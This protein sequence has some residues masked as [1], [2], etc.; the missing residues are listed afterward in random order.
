MLQSYVPKFSYII[1]FRFRS[2]RI[3]PLKRVIEW[4]SGFQGVE[5]I[6]VE[7][8]THSKIDYMNLK[9]NHVF[10]PSSAPF[11]KSWAFNVGLRRAISPVI[12]F[13]DADFI[14]HPMELIECLK[15]LDGYDCVIPT[16]KV[17][18]LTQQQSAMDTASLLQQNQFMM[19]KNIL[20]GI[21]IFKRD[22]LNKIAGW[23]EDLIGIGFENDFMEMKVKKMLNFKMLDYSGF[24][25]FHHPDNSP[26]S[27]I[28]RNR[29][30][31]ELYKKDM[32]MLDQ[33]I[34]QTSPKIGISSRFAGI[35]V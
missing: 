18:N 27:L 13:G 17:V 10:I 16:N 15:Q 6:I 3:L 7:Q 33:H 30:I 28:E 2:D 34:S 21:S 5:I 8:D 1:P 14:M 19:K 20:D 12:I 23:N 35:M 26:Q 4:L 22:P 11:N 25:I 32:N 24:H 9:A 31:F 29:N